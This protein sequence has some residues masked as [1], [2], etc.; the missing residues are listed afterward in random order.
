MASGWVSVE[1]S[2]WA[3]LQC[4]LRGHVDDPSDSPA[5]FQTGAVTSAA[6]FS[7]CSVDRAISCKARL[8]LSLKCLGAI[9]RRWDETEVTRQSKKRFLTCFRSEERRVG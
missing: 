8:M 5:I 9:W 6:F 7:V 4:S 3:S 2:Q 1:W